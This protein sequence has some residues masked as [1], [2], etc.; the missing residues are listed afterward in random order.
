MKKK[1]GFIGIGSIILGCVLFF[2]FWLFNLVKDIDCEDKQIYGLSEKESEQLTKL[3]EIVQK[4]EKEN[5]TIQVVGE[6]CRVLD[7]DGIIIK[8]SDA[9][10]KK[11]IKYITS[12]L[13]DCLLRNKIS[14]EQ[15]YSDIDALI[16]S[17]P[18]KN[19]YRIDY[20][21]DMWLEVQIIIEELEEDTQTDATAM[22]VFKEDNFKNGRYPNE[23]VILNGVEKVDDGMYRYT[24]QWRM[25]TGVYYIQNSITA[26]IKYSNQCSN[27]EI[28][29]VQNASGYAGLI[30]LEERESSVQITN[31]SLER[32]ELWSEAMCEIL[33]SIPAAVQVSMN[34][35]YSPGH[36]MSHSWTIFNVI[37]ASGNKIYPYNAYYVGNEI[38]K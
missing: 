25:Y 15:M 1:I 6:K 36:N 28:L 8:E 29:S 35:P 11:E 24:Y 34:D 3:A 10:T 18:D 2:T 19:T 14:L 5:L 37:R 4:L 16:A 7:E 38:N 13:T 31:W 9:V 20:E 26:S 12:I 32:P 21:N 30:N 27:V 17:E 23:T 33:C 22:I